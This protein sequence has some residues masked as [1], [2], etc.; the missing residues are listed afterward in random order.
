MALPAHI[1]PDA[2]VF[3][4]YNYIY[5]AAVAKTINLA[6]PTDIP[7]VY[8]EC[9]TY[10]LYDYIYQAILGISAAGILPAG[11]KNQALNLDNTTGLPVW[12]NIL[13]YSSGNSSFDYFNSFWY[14]PDGVTKMVSYDGANNFKI[15]DNA[16]VDAMVISASLRT[17]N[18]AAGGASGKF[19]A[20]TLNNAA[21][22]V[23]FQWG[24]DIVITPGS[25]NIQ[26]LSTAATAPIL[27]KSAGNA[28]KL[29]YNSQAAKYVISS[30]VS[31]GVGATVLNG[32]YVNVDFGDGV[33]K[34]VMLTD[35]SA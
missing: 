1:P 27:T 14:Y 10:L 30:D 17:V 24:T 6:L 5:K 3:D 9:P 21:N 18:D 12:T 23:V 29:A 11:T 28:L 19:N 2:T 35:A 13:K 31:G 34:Q 4:L 7:L 15:K 22:V 33:T 26:L 16:G 25:G 32:K 8:G 20:R